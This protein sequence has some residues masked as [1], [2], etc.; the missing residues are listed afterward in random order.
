MTTVLDASAVLALLLDEPGAAH[1]AQ[2][3]PDCVLGVVNLAEVLSKLSDRGADVAALSEQLST[4]G[5]QIETM[6]QLDAEIVSDL[7]RADTGRILSLGDR[8]CLALGRRLGT[9]VLT[10]DRA[11]SG[12]D[13]GVEVRQIR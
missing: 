4:A 6:T 2:A 3:L 13:V 7:R 12:L 8:C 11:W 5:L 10:A 9:P 1:V